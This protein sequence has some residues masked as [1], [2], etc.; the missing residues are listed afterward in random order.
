MPLLAALAGLLLVALI[1][2]PQWW[3]HRTLR[4]HAGERADLPGTGGELAR[5]LLDTA[6]LGDVKV[7]ALPNDGDHYDP[8]ARAV[9][10][11]PHTHDGRS[12]T[13][14]AIAVHEVGHALQHA[15]GDRLLAW[16]IRLAPIVRGFEIAAM[17]VLGA[18]PLT[19][20][21]VKAPAFLML[22]LALGIGLLAARVG[23]HLLTLPVELDASFGRALPIIARG[24]FLS[25]Q[26]LPAARSVLRA[27]A[28]T[29]VAS[30]L[31]TLLNVARWFRL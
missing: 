4:A 3:V 25:A 16:R 28:F 18:A 14:V 27:A 12:V 15:D 7:E 31:V 10:L 1:F 2:G 26:D 9:R 11:G 29:Y 17:V 5:H 21:F 6:G 30:A 13:A 20:I 24:G 8:I 23:M 22:Q 19:L